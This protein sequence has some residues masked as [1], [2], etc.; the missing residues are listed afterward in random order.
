MDTHRRAKLIL[1][2]EDIRRLLSLSDGARVIAARVEIDPLAVHILLE[3][4][5]FDEVPVNAEAPIVHLHQVDDC[6]FIA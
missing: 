5:R 3:S 6:A 1:D 4:P 2:T